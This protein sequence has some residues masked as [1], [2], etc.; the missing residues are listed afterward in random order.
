MLMKMRN[1]N[2]EMYLRKNGNEKNSNVVIQE[3]GLLMYLEEM[4]ISIKTS[5]LNKDCVVPELDPIDK[6]KSHILDI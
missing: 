4:K 6:I 1:E 3:M 5:M 2:K